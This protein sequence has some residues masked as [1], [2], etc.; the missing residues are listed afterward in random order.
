MNIKNTFFQRCSFAH[1]WRFAMPTSAKPDSRSVPY[2]VASYGEVDAFVEEQMHRL[3]GPGISLVI[4]K[5]DNR[6]SARLWTSLP[7]W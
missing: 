2:D 6:T 4:V 7:G 1:C 3:N 5:G